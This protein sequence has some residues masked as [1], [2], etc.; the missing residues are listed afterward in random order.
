MWTVVRGGWPRNA[1]TLGVSLEELVGAHGPGR[2]VSGGTGGSG[3]RES[4]F[5]LRAQS[6]PWV[7]SGR[8]EG[9]RGRGTGERLVLKNQNWD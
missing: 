4:R 9:K 6:P 5:E 3:S 1:P 8:R 2:E 7:L